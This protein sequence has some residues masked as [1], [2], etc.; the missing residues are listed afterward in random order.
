MLLTREIICS[1]WLC[2]FICLTYWTSLLSTMESR[3]PMRMVLRYGN[4]AASAR[5]HVNSVCQMIK[6]LI[7]D[8]FPLPAWDQSYLQRC[9][10][11]IAGAPVIQDRS[12]HLHELR[13]WCG[14]ALRMS[15]GPAEVFCDLVAQTIA[16]KTFFVRVRQRHNGECEHFSHFTCILCVFFMACILCVFLY[17]FTLSQLFKIKI[18]IRT[19][20][21]ATA[22]RKQKRAPAVYLW[23]GCCYVTLRSTLHWL[24]SIGHCVT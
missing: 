11:G 5:H 23:F 10:Y 4:R 21:V 13:H 12:L 22:I 16:E 2:K 18:Y 7:L 17:I 20:S 6:L 15:W 9:D 19:T 3:F 14:V 1:R 24:L 8:V